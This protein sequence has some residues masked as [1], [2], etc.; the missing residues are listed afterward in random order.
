MGLGFRDVRVYETTHK[1]LEKQVNQ[2]SDD[3]DGREGSAR[4]EPGTV[5]ARRQEVSRS[6]PFRAGGLNT[7][8]KGK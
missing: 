5:E 6:H 4:R 2:K 3:E 8:S 7:R 1:I